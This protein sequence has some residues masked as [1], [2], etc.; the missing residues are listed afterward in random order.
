MSISR[1]KSRTDG[2]FSPLLITELE[3][4]H[5]LQNRSSDFSNGCTAATNTRAAVSDY[6]SVSGSWTSTVAGSG[7]N[8]PFLAEDLPSAS[9]FR[10]DPRQDQAKRSQ[11]AKS[12]VR[13]VLLVEDNPT[14]V[15]VV[16]E[17][18]AGSGLKLEL[19]VEKDGR[20]AIRYLDEMNQDQSQQVPALV[21]LDLNVPK[22]SGIEV[23]RQLRQSSRAKETPVIVVT[24][25]SA[26]VDRL[27][28]EQLGAN[29]YFLKPASLSAYL[30]LT[31]LVKSILK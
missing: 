5:N 13:T 7:W 3:L 18:L 23:L 31:K 10:P 2:A 15:F 8:S 14:D 24:S 19:H 21:L 1:L 22:V 25:S 17:V 9:Q 27:A 12:D 26:D 4:K 20:E 11:P 28:V 16:K 29:A 30:E 6:P